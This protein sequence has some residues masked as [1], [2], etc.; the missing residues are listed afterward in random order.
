MDSEEAIADAPSS[1]QDARGCYKINLIFNAFAALGLGVAVILILNI[2]NHGGWFALLG[3]LFGALLYCAVVFPRLLFGPSPASGRR[4]YGD[5]DNRNRQQVQGNRRSAKSMALSGFA[6]SSVLA[7]AAGY[8]LI[9]LPTNRPIFAF[10]DAI[11]AL[12]ICVALFIL[13]LCILAFFFGRGHRDG[14]RG[15]IDM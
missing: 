2:F 4:R 5:E 1:G 13:G 12:V 11:L 10:L 6:F 7:I 9:Y 14:N 8:G 15:Y 3:G